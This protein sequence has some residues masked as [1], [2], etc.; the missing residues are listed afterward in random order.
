MLDESWRDDVRMVFE[1]AKLP[2]ELQDRSSRRS[3]VLEP[4]LAAFRAAFSSIQFG[5][6]DNISII[7]AQA[8]VSNGLRQVHLCGGLAYHPAIGHDALVFVLLHE[9]GHHLSGGCRMRWFPEMA[10]DCAADHWAITEGRAILRRTGCRFVLRKAL[11]QIGAAA[12][13]GANDNVRR[14]SATQCPSLHW[15]TRRQ[16]LQDNAISLRTECSII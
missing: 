4:V 15:R 14:K 1:E 6:F 7:N 9:T 10:C 13:P 3:A 5:I 8:C 11:D 2:P 12:A 16:V